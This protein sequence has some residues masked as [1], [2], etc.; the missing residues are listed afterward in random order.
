MI[1]LDILL[2]GGVLL[3]QL[4]TILAHQDPRQLRIMGHMVKIRAEDGFAIET[5]DSCSTSEKLYQSILRNYP[6]LIIMEESLFTPC[7]NCL[8]EKTEVILITGDKSKV[9]AD[10][11]KYVYQPV[12]PVT[13]MRKITEIVSDSPLVRDIQ[14]PKAFVASLHFPHDYSPAVDFYV[15]N[16]HLTWDFGIGYTEQRQRIFHGIQ[17]GEFSPEDREQEHAD[18]SFDPASIINPALRGLWGDE[19]AHSGYNPNPDPPPR[20]ATRPAPPPPPP[21]VPEDTQVPAEPVR[22][23]PEPPREAP[24]P[25]VS[26]TAQPAGQENVPFVSSAFMDDPELDEPAASSVPTPGYAPKQLKAAPVP[27]AP[28]IPPTP[29]SPAETGKKKSSAVVKPVATGSSMPPPPTPEELEAMMK[30]AQDNAAMQSVVPTPAAPTGQTDNPGTDETQVTNFTFITPVSQKDKEHPPVQPEPQPASEPAPVL[31]TPVQKPVPVPPEPPA[32][33]GVNQFVKPATPPAAPPVEPQQPQPVPS[34]APAAPAQQQLAPAQVS[35]PP[36]PEVKA[37]KVRPKQS[38]VPDIP[39]PGDVVG[40]EWERYPDETRYFLGEPWDIS[41]GIVVAVHA[42]GTREQ[43]QLQNNMLR[44]VRYTL[45]GEQMGL[46]NIYGF[47]L[48]I[49]VYYDKSKR[50]TGIRISSIPDKYIYREGEPID[51]T[52]FAME[53]TYNDGSAVP[54]TRY[55][56]EDKP[57]S[58]EQKVITFRYG[59][60]TVHQYIQV[61][62]LHD[63]EPA[64]PDPA[65]IE[66]ALKPVLRS[67]SLVTLPKTK[68]KLGDEFDPTSG[69]VLLVYEDGTQT[70]ESLSLDMVSGLDL[71]MAGKQTAIIQVEDKTC[72]L[73][74]TIEKGKGKKRRSKKAPE[75][76]SESDTPPMP[77]EEPAPISGLGSNKEEPAASPVQSDSPAP[78]SPV[79]EEPVPE[80]PGKPEAAPTPV[81]ELIPESEPE[82]VSEPEPEPVSRELVSVMLAKDPHKQYAAGDRFPIPLYILNANYSDGYVEQVV[83]DKAE[84]EILAVGT[85]LVTLTY[86]GHSVKVPVAVSSKQLVALMIDQQPNRVDYVLG[87]THL[88]MTGAKVTLFYSDNSFASSDVPEDWV[89]GFDGSKAGKQNLTITHEGKSVNFTVTVSD[90]AIEA[91]NIVKQPMKI[92]Y[93]EGELFDPSGMEVSVKYNDGYF[94]ERAPFTYDKVPLKTDDTQVL[95]RVG[96]KTAPVYVEVTASTV[97]KIAME[98]LPI[99]TIYL[100]G[101]RDFDPAGALVAKFSSTGEK[102]IVPL[103]TCQYTGF[104]SLKAGNCRILVTVDGCTCE[105]E[106]SI[107]RRELVSLRIA[108]MPVKT[109]YNDGD[110]FDPTG[111]LLAAEYNDGTTVNV[112]NYVVASKVL[113]LEDKSITAQF[114]TMTVTIPIIVQGR[115]I[116]SV[117]LAQMPNKVSYLVH[118]DELDMTGGKLLV[119]YADGESA[120]VDI[121]NSMVTGFNNTVIGENVV[122][123]HYCNAVTTLSLQIAAA[124]LIGIS[125]QKNPARMTYEEGDFFDKTGMEV[126]AFFNNG[127]QQPLTYYTIMPETPLTAKD[128]SVQIVYMNKVTTLPITVKPRTEPVSSG[129]PSLDGFYPDTDGLRFMDEDE[130]EDEE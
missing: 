110:V 75:S 84:P 3:L 31:P 118:Q 56:Y 101:E 43:M 111:L 99:K 119:V 103:S 30:M 90:R 66:Q 106:V 7:I 78:M 49:P 40:M 64:I 68:Y 53:K 58:L 28:P 89:S 83:A 126:T 127:Q 13:I 37:P 85:S 1:V 18:T 54:L 94:G 11:I 79:Q 113:T 74:I 5:L 129:L 34:A 91:I 10:N 17:A 116:E 63:P 22:T 114:E 39:N 32:P 21:H 81:P 123:I 26:R 69:S 2:E 47:T 44:N 35:V 65:L 107:M 95:I 29:P 125:I 130:D 80:E 50:L 46:V 20:R 97:S 42:D 60:R 82:F 71:Q 121:T 12:Q 67:I 38:S 55:H 70:I 45:S 104:S 108:S 102:D 128:T 100:E 76:L 27:P 96:D 15:Q 48:Q 88:D 14:G 61:R 86:Q 98:A 115:Q 8:V 117:V 36:T 52:G 19:P 57:V 112:T 120:V 41:D 62:P 122:S 87:E 93:H 72:T 92:T 9:D 77:V 23:A 105:F 16:K 24:V 33:S 51:L 25:P 4:R 73:A 6:S 124:Q 109:T 59:K